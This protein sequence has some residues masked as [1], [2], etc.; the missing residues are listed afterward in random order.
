MFAADAGQK[1]ESEQQAA[2][3]YGG[4]SQQLRFFT[5]LLR[6]GAQF[7]PQLLP[8]GVQLCLRFGLGGLRLSL[9]FWPQGL[10]LCLQLLPVLFPVWFALH[11]DECWCGAVAVAHLTRKPC[12]A[13]R[14][15][16]GQGGFCSIFR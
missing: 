2:G 13:G 9:P 14:A 8:Q 16:A 1:P 10:Q 3:H 11:D 12:R 15:A 5:H 6:Q 4:Y 7:V